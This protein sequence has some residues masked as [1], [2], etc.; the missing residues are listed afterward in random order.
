MAYK[1]NAHNEP[2]VD[3][4]TDRPIREP[5]KKKRIR[6]TDAEIAAELEAKRLAENP[7]EPPKQIWRPMFMKFITQLKIDS[8]ETGYG[9][10]IPYGAQLRFLDEV[11]DGLEAG[12]RHFVCLKARQLGISTIS[13][14][15]DLFWL[16][17]HD[18][19]QGAL[20][21]DDESNREKFRILLERYIESL[22]RGYRVGIKKHNRNNLVLQNGSVLDY[23]VAGKRKGKPMGVSRALNF[24]H[25]TEMSN[26]GDPD[27]VNSLMAALAQ[28]YPDRLYIFESTA[29]GYNLFWDMWSDAQEDDL[30]QKAFFIGWWS[31]EVY[32]IKQG[33]PL[34]DR[35]GPA[36]S[37]GFTDYEKKITREVSKRYG[38][39]ISIEQ[40]AWHRW[41]RTAK[42][43]TESSMMEEYPSTEDEAWVMTGQSFF[44]LQKL[45]NTVKELTTEKPMFKAYRYHMGENFLATDLEQVYQSVE[46]DLRVYEDWV[47]GANYVI[48]CD[49]AYGRSDHKDR[50]CI[51]VYRCFAD[52]IIQVAEYATPDC[53]SFQVA[54]VLAH[55]AGSYKNCIV[56]LEING[57]GEAVY[58]ELSHLKQLMEVGSLKGESEAK[59]LM[60]I[61]SAVRSYL[62]RRSDSI[63]GMPSAYHWKTTASNKP[64]ILNQMR[65]NYSLGALVI[66]S[67]HLAEEMKR[68]VQDGGEIQAEGRAKDDRVFAT[69]LANRAWIDWVRQPMIAAGLTHEIVMQAEENARSDKPR[70]E[71]MVNHIV[72]GF[73]NRLDSDKEQQFQEWRRSSL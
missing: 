4:R 1:K 33:T 22:P 20:I 50:H 71:T 60:D 36:F 70:P 41:M 3:P 40:W 35:Y 53:E 45:S 34:F 24:V 44:N 73:F 72:S 42:I 62:Y 68:V 12:I 10:L 49:P 54:W 13:L 30:T 69:A 18:G 37:A 2:L 63:G 43:T 11:C 46:A 65:D 32:S 6:K 14:A 31:K 7:P 5:R 58:R 19:I 57:P 16:S 27:A 47:P 59:G 61:F 8:K 29:R 25:A 56:N 26:W 67:I 64:V 28:E 17:V 9:P 55:L 66:K 38:V 23:I 15:M 48:G 21:T 51:E 52:K 39:E